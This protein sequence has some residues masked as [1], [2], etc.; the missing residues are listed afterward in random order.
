[1]AKWKLTEA[2]AKRIFAAYMDD[3]SG[4]D[5]Y[6]QLRKAVNDEGQRG[7]DAMGQMLKWVSENHPLHLVALADS[8]SYLY[9]RQKEKNRAFLQAMDSLAN[10]TE[11]RHS[12]Q[13]KK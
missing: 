2:S 10:Q 8:V 12:H 9:E 6:L 13:H 4:G 11:Y 3:D 5:S 1:M 7:F